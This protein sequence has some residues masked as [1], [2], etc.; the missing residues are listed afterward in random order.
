MKTSIYKFVAILSV[1]TMFAVTMPFAVSDTCC[2][3]E[4][5]KYG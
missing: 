5:G 4:S 1:V 2:A 3:A